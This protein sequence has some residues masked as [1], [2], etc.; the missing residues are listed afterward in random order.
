MKMV[1]STDVQKARESYENSSA[2]ESDI[3]REFVKGNGSMTH[4]LNNLPFMRVE[5][6]MR[7]TR[8]IKRMMEEGKISEAIKI[9]KIPPRNK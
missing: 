4:M 8:I 9:K 2:E 1:S 3:I 5:G 7:I 6:E